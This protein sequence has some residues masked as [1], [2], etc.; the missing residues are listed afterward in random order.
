M[1]T[2]R[3]IV[4]THFPNEKT[5][6]EYY[7]KDAQKI[8]AKLIKFKDEL[9]IDDITVKY[10]RKLSKNIVYSNKKQAFEQKVDVYNTHN[11]GRFYVKDKPS[12]QSLPSKISKTLIDSTRYVDFDIV[13]SA[14]S[15]LLNICRIKGWNADFLAE[16]C[17][18]RDKYLKQLIKNCKIPRKDAKRLFITMMFGG[19]Y[20]NW[21]RDMYDKYP[22]FNP[23]TTPE[24][25]SNIHG[26]LMN[27]M[28]NAYECDDFKH[29]KSN[30]L[31]KKKPDTINCFDKKNPKASLLAN[32]LFNIENVI[33]QKVEHYIIH[34]TTFKVDTP[35]FDGFNLRIKTHADD[36][37]PTKDELDT[38]IHTV[39]ELILE[40]MGL[41]INFALKDYNDNYISKL[42]ELDAE[43]NTTISLYGKDWDS[44]ELNYGVMDEAEAMKKILEIYPHFKICE[45]SL[46]MYK[47]GLW[48]N[49]V[50]HIKTFFGEN[51]DYIMKLKYDIGRAEFINSN[52]SFGR[53]ITLL[54]NLL[55]SFN[56]NAHLIDNKLLNTNSTF[57]S[58]GKILF[59][60]GVLSADKNGFTFRKSFDNNEIFKSRIEDDFRHTQDM[61]KINELREI[62]F[63]RM[64][65]ENAEYVIRFIAC[66]LFGCTL[67]KSLFVIGRTNS[68][69]SLLSSLIAT[70]FTKDIIGNFELK[71]FIY[72]KFQDGDVKHLNWVVKNAEKRLLISNES[73]NGKIDVETFKQVCSGGTDEIQGRGL[74]QSEKEVIPKFMMLCFMNPDKMPTFY[75]GDD[76]LKTR[77]DIVKL[78]GGYVT[79]E[80]E[81]EDEKLDF[82]MEDRNMLVKKYTSPEYCDAM[83]MLF[84]NAYIDYLKNGLGSINVLETDEI[85]EL[86][87]GLNDIRESLRE[88]LEYADGEF[89]KAT[90]FSDWVNANNLHHL[91]STNVRAKLMK[92]IYKNY[93]KPYVYSRKRCDGGN[94]RGYENIRFKC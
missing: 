47:D 93:G 71:K 87:D 82:L 59:K 80:D 51:S 68:G 86:N 29:I 5:Y 72:Q 35:A 92:E 78:R 54:N 10:L 33:I 89:L 12:F 32:I 37:A 53:S 70:N 18:N 48:T 49:D 66:A 50:I 57:T 63:T 64:Y 38:L 31:R 55:T 74:Y 65:Q 52:F 81:I 76:A 24:W 83:R 61:D 39:E 44:Q 9:S 8:I 84:I 69:K 90:E 88:A 46:F 67:K 19:D 60:N 30:I 58:R 14:P 79:S 75:G 56:N 77:I 91:R 26:E 15:I 16:Y 7:R 40:D 45:G 41:Y 22:E 25:V 42:R 34:N 36:I 13:N 43:D 85:D 3:E 17:A 62:F 94:I 6:T 73:F 4:E 23:E 20:S 2:I 11:T 28:D 21:M 1:A 27:I